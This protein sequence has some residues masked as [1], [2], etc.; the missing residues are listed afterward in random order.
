LAL[1]EHGQ[2]FLHLV[3]S[4]HLGQP[5]IQ[6]P[7]ERGLCLTTEGDHQ[8]GT[9]AI[10]VIE[11][12]AQPVLCSGAGTRT[13]VVSEI[14]TRGLWKMSRSC[15]TASKSVRRTWCRSRH[16]GIAVRLFG[17][18]GLLLRPSTAVRSSKGAGAVREGFGAPAG[19]PM[20][21]AAPR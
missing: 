3:W 11:Q 7:E 20:V 10:K 18:L 2:R 14:P 19:S 16:D 12:P 8:P 6:R 5:G 17:W 1:F 15:L 9:G 13:G 21:H 4:E